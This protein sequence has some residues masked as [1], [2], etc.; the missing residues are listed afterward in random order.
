MLFLCSFKHGCP[1]KTSSHS[2]VALWPYP[3]LH[4]HVSLWLSYS[5]WHAGIRLV[6]TSFPAV[7]VI[8]CPVS[9]VGHTLAE[10]AW[11]E[12][13]WLFGCLT[14]KL[15]ADMTQASGVWKPI[16]IMSKAASMQPAVIKWM[17][18]FSTMLTPS[19]SPGQRKMI[20]HWG[21]H[22]D[23]H[24]RLQS[25]LVSLTK[26][27]SVSP[28]VCDSVLWCCESVCGVWVFQKLKAS[29]LL[30]W[31]LAALSRKA[32]HQ[33]AKFMACFSIWFQLLIPL[34]SATPVLN[35]KQ[36]NNLTPTFQ[37]N[38]SSFLTVI[39]SMLSSGAGQD[40]SRLKQMTS[41]LFTNCESICQNKCIHSDLCM[42]NYPNYPR[43]IDKTNA[44]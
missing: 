42:C 28:P 13:F 41:S 39:I 40:W 34:F 22:T 20:S 30:R 33:T 25:R 15:A 43:V 31:G 19:D 17:S 3:S 8:V 1:F 12:T 14:S 2:V 24:T 29:T 26:L 11:L 4:N 21:P 18:P 16:S 10:M 35:Q 32:E 27:P 36:R 7:S 9:V 37:L 5:V 38:C 44:V 6:F 23:T